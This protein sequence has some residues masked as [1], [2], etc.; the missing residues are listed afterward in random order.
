MAQVAALFAALLGASAAAGCGSTSTSFASTADLDGATPI[1]RL[2]VVADLAGRGFSAE[3]Y[4]GFMEGLTSRLA[5][6]GVPSKIVHR[7]P[8]DLD[9]DQHLAE[10]TK[11]FR[12][13]AAMSITATDGASRS[14]NGGLDSMVV[15][16]D[17]E[18]RDLKAGKQIWRARSRLYSRAGLTG[19][20]RDWGFSFAT[21]VVMR[22]RDDGV[23]THCPPASADWPESS[24]CAH[25]TEGC[26][27]S[28]ATTTTAP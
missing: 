13:S 17:L 7:N 23:L 18:I 2:L 25:R 19:S 6:C 27:P 24:G 21:S 5:T 4:Q 11:E 28:A 12:P 9:P 16:S 10:V 15:D 8:M 20:P 22:L 14:L 3:M 1:E 26:S